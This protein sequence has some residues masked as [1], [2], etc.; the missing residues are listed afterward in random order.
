MIIL[1]K[2]YGIPNDIN[3]GWVYSNENIITYINNVIHWVT[4]MNSG[5]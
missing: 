4:Y 5:I 2:K 1:K 3:N